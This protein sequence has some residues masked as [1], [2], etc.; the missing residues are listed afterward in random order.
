MAV[1]VVSNLS[2]WSAADAITGWVSDGDTPALYNIFQ[3]E[4]SGNLGIQISQTTTH[5]YIPT[6]TGDAPASAQDLSNLRIYAWV[7][8]WGSVDTKA[9]GGFRIVLGD[10]TNRRAYY[11][12]GS[13]DYGFQ[14]G[15]WTCIVL[16][17]ANLP[18]NF[19]QLAGAA[20][21]T[22]TAITQV[23]VGSKY[24]NKATG[25]V[26]NF[27]WDVMRFGLGLTVYGGSAGSPA[28][29]A[30]IAA[31]DALTSTGKA[32]GVI[33]ELQAG[34]Y[35][36]QGDLLFGD[37]AGTNALYFKDDTAIVVLEDR[38]HG[39]GTPT[40]VRIHVRANATHADQHFELGVAVGT[41]DSQSGR[42]GVTFLNANLAQRAEFLANDADLHEFLAYGCTWNGIDSGS[43]PSV[44]FSDDATLAANH[45][46]SGCTFARCGSVGIGR[47]PAR[48][49]TWS[50]Y[51]KSANGA[52]LWNDNISIKNS[53]FIAN[54]GTSA[55]AIEHPS[56]A[57]SPYQY[58]NLRF[59]GND[60]DVN[61]TSGN[62][63]TI[64]KLNGSDPNTSKGSGVTFQGSFS[65]T[66]TNLVTGSE[67][68]VLN[69]STGVELSGTESSGTSFVHAHNG[70]AIVIRVIIM[71]VDYEWL[72]ITDTLAS[73]NQSN[74][75]IQRP[76]RNYANP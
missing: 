9:N 76:D 39:A 75:V 41:G 10:G 69:D 33:R 22:L 70:T 25:N 19:A 30:E 54:T 38:V 13:D 71:H 42:D 5:V 8:A 56:S 63:I 59:S 1:T 50:G 49:C 27:Y 18:S 44:A 72:A 17:T 32:H 26:D 15:G 68:R 16:D 28:T 37:D 34:V 46:L 65:Y 2:L 64:D 35:G 62:A 4:G 12:G 3:R 40:P 20:A 61:N 23:G 57:G 14:V 53:Q 47:V 66:L 45:R 60:F 67:V 58:D 43:S 48:N 29:F 21:P 6:G 7:F 24:L 31:D 51:T 55:S 11:V 36:V 73:A 74:K 52:L